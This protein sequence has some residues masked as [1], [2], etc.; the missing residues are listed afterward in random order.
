VIPRTQIGDLELHLLDAGTFRL[1]GGAM[2]RVIPRVLWE[3]RCPPDERNRILLAMRPVLVRALDG[4]WV[5]V[6]SGIGAARRD[7]KFKDMFDVREAS[8]LEASF[9][10]L[11]VR[12]DEVSKIVVTHMHFDHVG[13]IAPF[14]NAKLVVQKGELEDA[15]AGCELCKASYVEQDWKALKD[16]G[17]LEVVDGDREVAPGIS[18]VKTGGHTRAHQIVRFS[19]RGEE[20]AFWGDLIPTSAH[21]RPHYVMAYDLYPVDCWRAKKE[22]VPR[23]VEEGWTNVFYHDPVSPLGRVRPDGR[24]FRVEAPSEVSR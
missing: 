18:V 21:L 14:A 9:A 22:L 4:S 2:F 24:D 7:P 16:S 5:L 11:G 12:P 17:R 10:S 23:A 8:P 1:D 19:S 20:G 15:Y 13:G 6:E 3:N